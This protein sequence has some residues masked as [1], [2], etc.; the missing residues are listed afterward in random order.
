MKHFSCLPQTLPLP[1]GRLPHFPL[2]RR[3]LCGG[4]LEHMDQWPHTSW[5][6]SKSRVKAAS[7]DCPR[8][9][10]MPLERQPPSP[11]CPW[12][13]CVFCGPRPSW[14]WRP[15]EGSKAASPTGMEKP[16]TQSWRCS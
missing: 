9:D 11:T 12:G 4:S 1:T 14:G 10:L 2:P 3:T 16:C 7:S 5:H 6:A 8:G 15:A 13:A